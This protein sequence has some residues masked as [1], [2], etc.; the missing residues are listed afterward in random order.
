MLGISRQALNKRLV[1][2]RKVNEKL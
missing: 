1:R 2:G